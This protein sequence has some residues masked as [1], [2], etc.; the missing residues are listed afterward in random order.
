[1]YCLGRSQHAFPSKLNLPRCLPLLEASLART[2]SDAFAEFNLL[3]DASMRTWAV[4]RKMDTGESVRTEEVRALSCI[5]RQY[6][7]A[8]QLQISPSEITKTDSNLYTDD[9]P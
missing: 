7:L 6:M 4:M 1:M 9:S 2:D 3:F 5:R 8:D